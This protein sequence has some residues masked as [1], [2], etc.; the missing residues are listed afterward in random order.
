MSSQEFINDMKKLFAVCAISNFGVKICQFGIMD[1]FSNS[2]FG[3]HINLVVHSES[4]CS[5]VPFSLKSF[6]FS[7]FEQVAHTVVPW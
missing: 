6:H 3:G 5:P 4:S 1:D 7:I 2:L